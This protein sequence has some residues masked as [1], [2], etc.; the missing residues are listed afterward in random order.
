[1]Q[2]ATLTDAELRALAYFAVGVG[3]EGGH[4]GRDASYRLSFA[5]NIRDGVM[6]PIGNSGY[7]IGTL[8]TDLG[9][10][11]DVAGTLVDA[12]QTWART[13]HPGWVL[14]DAE[15]TQ[16]INDLGRNGRTIL[17]QNGRALDATVK[18]H[19]DSFLTSD[20]G[21][22]FVHDRDAAQVERLMRSG[23]AVDQLQETALYRNSTPDEQAI[24]ATMLLKIE[25]QGGR[26]YYPRIINGINSG[27]IGSIEDV[28]ATI[29]EFLPNRNNRPDYIE[30]G[31]SHAL[32]ATQ[33]FN[34]LRKADSESPLHQ[35]WRNVLS[36]PLVNPTQTDQDAARPNLGSEYSAVKTLFLQKVDSPAFIAALDQGGAY[37]YNLINSRGQSRPQSTR[38]YAAGNDFVVMDGNGIG[39]AYVGGAWSDVNRANITRSNISDGAVDLN[40]NRDGAVERLMRIDPNAPHL[41]PAEQ[42]AAERNVPVDNHQGMHPSGPFNDPFADRYF[43]A[44]MAGDSALADQIAVEFSQTPEGQ[45]LAQQGDQLLAQQQV[46][47]QRQLEE[48]Q[49]VQRGPVMQM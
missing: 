16:T 44:V 30:S 48:R 8:Q 42:P 29:N 22:T 10:H 40:I 13:E 4:G 32:D 28:R 27:A 26:G 25:N 23:G 24:L 34:H 36:N 38:L 47:E 45:Q 5:G 41:R 37:G 3:S 35:P 6:Q 2:E 12:Y 15:R 14:S 19:L 31:V 7:S 49:R 9:Q 46:L 1:M 20:A 17:A 39:K 21:I 43:A 18:S 33:V 11:P